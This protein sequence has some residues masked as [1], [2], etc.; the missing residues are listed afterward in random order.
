MQII[1]NADL[2]RKGLTLF[3]AGKFIASCIDSFIPKSIG[4]IAVSDKD[5]K[6]CF[7]KFKKYE[8]E[9]FTLV[10]HISKNTEID[11][12]DEDFIVDLKI[13]LD[14]EFNTDI[15]KIEIETE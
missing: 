14:D 5:I 2:Y 7:V 15:E 1:N 11:S 12:I 6:S 10:G 3:V 13:E 4:T 8:L 9:N